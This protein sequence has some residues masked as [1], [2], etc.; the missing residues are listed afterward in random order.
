MQQYAKPNRQ[1][2]PPLGDFTALNF[3]EPRRIVFNNGIPCYFLATEEP[4]VVILEMILG[5][6]CWHEPQPKVAELTA[7]MLLEGT[8]EIT[9]QE[10]LEKIEYFGASI[11]VKSYNDFAKISIHT[12]SQ[13][14]DDLLP[15]LQKILTDSKFEASDFDKLV[16]NRQ[17]KLLLKEDK[18]EYLAD[19]IFHEKLS[20]EALKI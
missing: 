20:I 18:V 3:P 19:V 4:D 9:G 16:K 1:Q 2:P 6:G 13:Y 7:L 12:L 14:L 5:A 10:L 15:L 11:R 8:H 17:H